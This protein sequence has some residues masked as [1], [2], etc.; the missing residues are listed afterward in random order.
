MSKKRPHPDDTLLDSEIVIDP[1]LIDDSSSEEPTSGTQPK[2]DL[3]YGQRGA[4]P[5]LDDGYGDDELFYGPANDG[6][7]YLRMVR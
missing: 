2:A 4:F 5:G 1:A 7:Q 3:T 6:L